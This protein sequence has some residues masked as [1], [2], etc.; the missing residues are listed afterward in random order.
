M[1][2]YK[3]MRSKI[4]QILEERGPMTAD[5]I[6]TVL[7]EKNFSSS[8]HGSTMSIA[9]SMRRDKTFV[10]VGSVGS[11]SLWYLRDMGDSQ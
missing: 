5:T 3:R 8:L 6:K 11:V 9:M 2:K 1:A 7:K 4:A 10:T